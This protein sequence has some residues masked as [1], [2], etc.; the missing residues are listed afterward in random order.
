MKIGLITFYQNNYGSILQCF[1][2]KSFLES[3]NHGCDVIYLREYQ[4]RDAITRLNKFVRLV[5]KFLCHP[6]FCIAF[7]K[8]KLRQKNATTR[9]SIKTAKELNSFVKSVFKPIEISNT[10]LKNDSVKLYD[11]F[12]AGS[13][14]IW[15]LS[16]IFY[17]FYFLAFAPREKRI[18]LAA[19]FGISSIPKYNTK[20][21]HNV[22][23]D[24]DYVSVREETGVEI[25]K[26]YSNAKVCRIAD[27]TFIYNADEW[28]EF[29][30][31]AVIPSQ[32]FILVHFLNKPNDV[33]L[34][35]MLWLS[36]Q[37]DLDIIAIGYKYDAFNGLKRYAFMD[38]GP[39][40]YLSMIDHAEFVLTDS[41]HSSLFSINYNKRFFVFHRNYSVSRQT[42]R[43]SDLLKRFG[44]E[45]RLIENVDTLKKIYLKSQPAETRNILQKECVTIRDYIQK[46]ITGQVPQCFLQ[47]EDNAT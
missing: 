15:N 38:G 47:G 30:K 12:I 8:F 4:R 18:A 24:F 11:W 25:V 7:I 34:E 20:E 23:N 21:L 16:L 17:S 10:V 33:A 45:E 36:E 3:L 5:G 26:K 28:R 27:P 39:W 13:D 43:I 9:L 32:N 35:S 29:A 31:D 41:F 14:Q 40:E 42:S 22:L 6:S 1:S 46:S 37:L 44:M 19:S 2:T